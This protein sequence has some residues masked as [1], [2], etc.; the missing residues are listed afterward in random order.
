M[1]EQIRC[2]SRM[3]RCPRRHKTSLRMFNSEGFGKHGQAPPSPYWEMSA[4]SRPVAPP[5]ALSSCF[6]PCHILG[7][8]MSIH[9]DVLQGYVSRTFVVYLCRP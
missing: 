1:Q 5:W 4:L 6:V 7:A 9:L 2:A 8:V 3:P